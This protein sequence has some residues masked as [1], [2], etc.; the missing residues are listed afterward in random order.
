MKERT[1]KPLCGSVGAIST[2]SSSIGSS[3]ISS[4]NGETVTIVRI[5]GKIINPANW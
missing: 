3:S 4:S 1:P 2:G 5:M